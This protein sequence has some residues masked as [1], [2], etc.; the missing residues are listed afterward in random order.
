MQDY[1]IIEMPPICVCS[2]H[3]RCPS[4]AFLDRGGHLHPLGGQ[5]DSDT[6]GQMIELL[7]ELRNI[8][9]QLADRLASV[10]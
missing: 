3:Y 6:G 8:I 5:H 9:E 7:D 4:C 2:P 1:E 10:R